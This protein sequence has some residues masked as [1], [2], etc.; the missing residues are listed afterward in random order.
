MRKPTK[1]VDDTEV[2]VV[3]ER[4]VSAQLAGSS[5]VP[6]NQPAA[7]FAGSCSSDTYSRFREEA[8]LGLLFCERREKRIKNSE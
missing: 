1:N 4:P 7:K 5:E 8:R 6:A 2:L 3:K